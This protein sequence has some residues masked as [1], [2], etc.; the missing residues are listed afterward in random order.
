MRPQAKECQAPPEGGRGQE[1]TLPQ[2]PLWE[3]SLAD[4]LISIQ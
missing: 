4:I 1:A 2:S 3:H